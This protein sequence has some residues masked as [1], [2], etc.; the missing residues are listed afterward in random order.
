MGQTSEQKAKAKSAGA[1]TRE[2]TAAR[3][4]EIEA[5]P[6][7]WPKQI[8]SIRAFMDAQDRDDRNEKQRKSRR[9][10][11]HGGEADQ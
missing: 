4:A 11:R 9:E 6:I 5:N 1:S 10:A 7:D 2:A 3:R 8:A